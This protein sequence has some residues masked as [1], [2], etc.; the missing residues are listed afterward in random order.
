MIN[1][2]RVF[3]AIALAGAEAGALLAFACGRHFPASYQLTHPRKYQSIAASK[4]VND[5]TRRPELA[6]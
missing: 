6:Y 5:E 1:D 2:C 4:N 3:C